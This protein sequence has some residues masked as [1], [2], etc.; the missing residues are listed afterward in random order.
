M[1]IREFQY[2]FHSVICFNADRARLPRHQEST[3]AK[4]FY[5]GR[6]ARV[7]TSFPGMQPSGPVS[8]DVSNRPAS[9][10]AGSQN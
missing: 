2:L 8:P 5:V 6:S 4:E 3:T 1:F 7:S 9:S 10:A